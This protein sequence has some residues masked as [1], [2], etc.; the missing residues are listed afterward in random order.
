MNALFKNAAFI[1]LFLR[2]DTKKINKVKTEKA[3]KSAKC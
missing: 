2:T 1:L 3:F